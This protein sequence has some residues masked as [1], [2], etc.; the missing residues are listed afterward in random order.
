METVTR[1]GL[2]NIDFGEIHDLRDMKPGTCDMKRGKIQ[3]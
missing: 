2:M 3:V 1:R